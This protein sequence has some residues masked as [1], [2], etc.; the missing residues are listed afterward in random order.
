MMGMAKRVV[1]C[2]DEES[3]RNPALLGL[4]EEPLGGIAWIECCATAEACREASRRESVEE[5][6][7]VSCDDM[8]PVNV[9][10]AL[11]SDDPF[12]KVYLAC[13]SNNGS[14]ASRASSANID[15]VLS[16]AAFVERFAQAKEL[17][18]QP[19]SQAQRSYREMPQRAAG[20]A[21]V[22]A[23]ARSA[24]ASKPVSGRVSKRYSGTVIVVVGASGGC[25]KGSI[26]ALFAVLCAKA[27][28]ATLAVD[29]DLQFGDMDRLLGV[30]EPVRVD[31]VVRDPTRMVRLYEDARSTGKP[32]LLAAPRKIEASELVSSE[33]PDILEAARGDYDVVIACAGAFW[34]ETHAQLIEAA[35]A[36]AFL[37]DS[38]PG[39]LAATVHAVE[40]CG[41]MGL[42]TS[43]F[44]YVVNKH[45]RD[46]LLS[47]VDASCALKGSAAVELPHGGR[48]VE[49]LLGAGF[50]ADFIESRNALVPEAAALLARLL[51]KEQA[52]KVAQVMASDGK[53]KRIFG[54]KAQR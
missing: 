48:D 3:L 29:A 33:L 20:Q 35:D 34:T 37:M 54:R 9:A 31:D 16:E 4:Q 32:S 24:V 52:D 25:G 40:L 49:E 2:A 36:V 43:S 6:W 7:V 1:L 12:K 11:K 41:R 14:L 15:G 42:A 28:L 39:S 51:P 8:E 53:F 26:A 47:A 19:T 45:E 50:P 5:A 44:T 10:A 27:G 30:K 21:A 22:A 13:G 17:W 46:S 23:E 18:G 38:R